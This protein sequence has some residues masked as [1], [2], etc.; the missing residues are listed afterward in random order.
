MGVPLP[1]RPEHFIRYTMG[2]PLDSDL[3]AKLA[4]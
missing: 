4:L 3:Y 1:I 2:R